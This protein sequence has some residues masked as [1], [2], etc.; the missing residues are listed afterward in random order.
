[1]RRNVLTAELLFMLILG[2]VVV[3]PILEVGLHLGWSHDA[4]GVVVIMV[5]LVVF[6]AARPLQARLAPRIG[7]PPPRPMGDERKA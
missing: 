3:I 6:F 4:L 1:M 2:W 7:I 5:G